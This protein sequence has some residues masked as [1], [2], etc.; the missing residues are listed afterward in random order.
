MKKTVYTLVILLLLVTAIATACS[1]SPTST[2]TK[3]PATSAPATTAATSTPPK[4]TAVTTTTSPTTT[5][6]AQPQPV[7][8]GILKF[9]HNQ[10]VNNVSAPADGRSFTPGRIWQCV[11]ETLIT[12]DAQENLKPLL[13]ESWTISPDGRAITFNLRKGIKFT[14]GTDF[15]AEAVKFNLE[16]HK[17]NNTTSSSYLSNVT[18]Y[19]IT[20]PYTFTILLKNFDAILVQALATTPLGAMASPTAVQKPATPDNIVQLHMVGTGPFKFVSWQRDNFI[21]F[22]KNPNYWQPGKPYLDGVEIRNV[23]DVTVSLISLKAKETNGVITVDPLDC[24]NLQKAGYE[25]MLGQGYYLHHLC[26]DSNNPDSPFANKKVREALEYAIDRV[27][28]SEG[29]G[30]GF[31]S[32]AYQFAAPEVAFYDPNLTPRKYD[33]KKAKQ[34]LA[35][36]GYPNGL[37]TTLVTDVRARVDTLT[38]VQTYL[39]EAGFDCTIDKADTTRFTEMTINGWKGILMP[40]A[41]TSLTLTSMVTRFNTNYPSMYRPA[42]WADKWNAVIAQPDYNKRVAQLKELVK[43]MYDEMIVIPYH[44]DRSRMVLD[45]KVKGFAFQATGADGWDCVNTWLSK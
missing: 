22:E 14:D 2:T 25:V 15:N 11:F 20:D 24:L 34:L 3:A 37:K 42:G 45:G 38:A 4:T 41:P 10:G 31:F 9:N 32:P 1:T 8:G 26:P 7:S 33:L 16:L 23:A 6:P 19:A 40:G 27:G 44:S 18:G 30:Y 12:C 43:I 35:E 17:K 28:L 21:K 13:A 36:A 5:T 39:K 29:I